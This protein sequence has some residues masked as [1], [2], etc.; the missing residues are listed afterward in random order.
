MLNYL[1]QE[2][3]KIVTE[4]GAATYFTTESDCLVESIVRHILKHFR[5]LIIV[6]IAP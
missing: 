4:N 6:S 1:K 2:A 3:N 5:I